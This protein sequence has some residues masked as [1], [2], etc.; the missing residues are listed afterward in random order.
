VSG[1]LI[2]P[3]AHLSDAELAD[4]VGAAVDIRLR[5]SMLSP[6][7][8]RQ[9]M[10]EN[11]CPPN[12]ATQ[13]VKDPRFRIYAAKF[14]LDIQDAALGDSAAKERVEFVRESW[15]AMAAKQIPDAKSA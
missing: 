5:L 3:Y 13:Q 6:G 2:Q 7:E 11:G 10:I 14:H 8:V 15:A 4:L 9:T 1:E 12:A